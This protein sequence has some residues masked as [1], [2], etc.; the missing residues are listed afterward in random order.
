MNV[1][2]VARDLEQ[3]MELAFC[4]FE[5]ALADLVSL[6]HGERPMGYHADLI[7]LDS[8]NWG[9]EDEE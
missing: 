4:H 6:P 1:V 9:M 2:N 5:D 3:E 7:A 8:R